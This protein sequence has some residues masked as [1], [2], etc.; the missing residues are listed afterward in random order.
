MVDSDVKLNKTDKK[1]YKERKKARASSW[2]SAYGANI[3]VQ[4]WTSDPPKMYTAKLSEIK[5]TTLY[6]FNNMQ[7]YVVGGNSGAKML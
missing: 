1:L 6:F 7:H 4:F 5:K 2:K 3:L